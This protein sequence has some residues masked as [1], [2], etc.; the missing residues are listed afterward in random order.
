MHEVSV[1]GGAQGC[2]HSGCC[3]LTK[4][5]RACCHTVAVAVTDDDDA[6]GR[7]DWP[8]PGDRHSAATWMR[9]PAWA[10]EPV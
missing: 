5:E 1:G 8:E 2:A 10:G 4:M 6:D 7:V 3:C 9:T